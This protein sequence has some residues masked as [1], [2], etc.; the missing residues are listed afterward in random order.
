MRVRWKSFLKVIIPTLLVVAT[1]M[2][3]LLRPATSPD[4]VGE[5]SIWTCSMHP[6]IRQTG[7]GKCPLCGM[8]LVPVSQLAA[9]QAALQTRAGLETEAVI[10]RELFKEIRTVGKLDYNER[11]VAYITARIAGRLDRLYADFPGIP[12][13]KG[14]HLADIYSP[15]LVVTVQNLLDSRQSGNR[16]LERM[17]SERLKLWGILPEQIRDIESSHKA[18]SHLTL[19]APIAGTIIEKSV[20]EGQYVK[21]GDTLYRIASLDF[22]W[23]YLD[24]YEYDLNW[25]RYG[26]KLE[27]SVEAFPGET[28][29]GQ[30]VFI[31]PVLDD[32]TRTVKVRANLPNPQQKLKPAMYASVTLRVR[33]RSDGTPEP[34]GLEGKYVSPMHPEIVRDE[35]GFCPICGMALVRVPEARPPAPAA[36]AGH[37]EGHEGHGTEAGQILAVRATAVLDTGRRKVA[38]RQTSSGNYELVELRLGPR[39]DGRNDAGQVIGYYPVLIGLQPGDRVVVRGGFLLDSERQIEGLP[40]LLYPEGQSAA[41]LHAGHGGGPSPPRESAPGAPHQH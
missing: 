33:L 31:D 3:L 7:P 4:A 14:D 38:Y 30:V 5:Q 39:A 10:Y 15:D 24:I 19:Y 9:E 36:H 16:E 21:E 41:N 8:D 12:V 29:H 6:Q 28:F 26:Q 34:T 11:Q 22:L 27:V 1:S 17:A 2:I 32:R 25:V 23:L 35:P 37:G 18:K 13:R 40:S 20:R